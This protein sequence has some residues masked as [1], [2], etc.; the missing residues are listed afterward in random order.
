MSCVLMVLMLLFIN[1]RDNMTFNEA[2]EELEKLANRNCY[3]L[4]YNHYVRLDGSV[5][6]ECRV[7]IGGDNA[8]SYTARNWENAINVVKAMYDAKESKADKNQ[9][10]D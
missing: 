6:Q 9:E 4:N 5:D 1:G 8:V 3:S 7:Y 2:K 10:P